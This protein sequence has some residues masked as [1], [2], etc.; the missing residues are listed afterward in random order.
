MIRP[1]KRSFCLTLARYATLPLPV[2]ARPASAGPTFRPS[3]RRRG[4]EGSRHAG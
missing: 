4:L 2:G 1:G 3:A